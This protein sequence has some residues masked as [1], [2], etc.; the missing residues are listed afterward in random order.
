MDGD[1]L[2][3]GNISI[4]T[5]IGDYDFYC[6]RPVC[7]NDLHGVGAFLLMCVEMQKAISPADTQSV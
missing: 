2:Q 5:G 4:G 7:V 3:I 6:H 1:D